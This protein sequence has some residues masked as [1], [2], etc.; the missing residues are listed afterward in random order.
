MDGNKPREVHF[1]ERGGTPRLSAITT[2]VSY[3]CDDTDNDMTYRM[4]CLT[5]GDSPSFK[6][7]TMHHLLIGRMDRGAGKEESKLPEDK[8]SSHG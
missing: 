5:V 2:R 6:A 1:E 8:K 7:A 3:D 4:C